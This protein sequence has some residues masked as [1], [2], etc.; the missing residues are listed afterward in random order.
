[1]ATTYIEGIAVRPGRTALQTV[2]D[3]ISYITNPLKTRDGKWVTGY[4]CSPDSAHYEILMQH[5]LA[6]QITGRSVI[7]DYQGKKK[8][9]LLMTMRQSFAPGEVNEKTAHELGCRLAEQF[10]GDKYQCVVATHV[11]TRC[12]HNHIIFNIVGDDFKK[13]HQTKFTPKRLAECSDNLCVAYG[14]SV[15]V[16]SQ[17][18]SKRTYTNSRVTPFRTILKNDIDRCIQAAKDYEEFLT[19]LE[20]DYYVKSSGKYLTVRNRTNGQQRNIRVYTLGEEYKEANIKKRI[21]NDIAFV[22]TGSTSAFGKFQLEENPIENTSY[23]Q[24]LRNI[25]AM[26]QASGVI[27]DYAVHEY[28]DLQRNIQVLY[29]SATAAKERILQAEDEIDK[30]DQLLIAMSILEKYDDIA[31][32]Y[33]HALLKDRFYQSHRKELDEYLNAEERLAGIP[34]TTESKWDLEQTVK[35][36]RKELDDLRSRYFDLQDKLEEINQAKRVIDKVHRKK[37][38][39]EY[40]R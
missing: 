12:I 3:S 9:Y 2:F 31:R 35:E 18:R 23:S 38:G 21:V 1:M 6:E 16:P 7:Q 26:F 13:F 8:S 4:K 34:V 36:S 5:R 25:Q 17:S 15:V 40:G 33:E 10:L 27:S 22:E 37:G 29:D 32:E 11:N 14:L 24:Q 28:S 39:Y 19:L 20:R 30:F